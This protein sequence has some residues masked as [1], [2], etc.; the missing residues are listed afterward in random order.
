MAP[1]PVEHR[2]AEPEVS[3]G[4]CRRSLLLLGIASLGALAAG[5]ASEAAEARQPRSEAVRER[6][7]A[8][9]RARQ[10]EGASAPATPAAAPDG[11]VEHPYAK[12][13][14]F[15]VEL[16]EEIWVNTARENRAIPWRAYLPQG[17]SKAPMV[18][19]SHGGGGTRESGRIYG[20]H[21]ASH[22]I[23]ALHLQHAGS[24][25]DAFRSNPQQISAAARDPALARPRFEDVGYAAARLA[26][27][28][29]PLAGRIDAERLGI[30]GHSFG[31]ITTLIVAGQSVTGFG[32]GF[33]LPKLLGA[34]ALSPSPP[35]AGYGDEATAFGD[36]LMPIFHLTGTED[37]APNG[38]FKAP[39]RR[40][41]FD[42]I[43]DVEQHLL[44]LKGANHFTFGGDP[45][46]R[47]GPR[48]FG[49][50]E[51]PRHHQLILAAAA[52]FWLDRM[53]QDGAARAF[54]REGGLA[55]LLG[56]GDSLEHKKAQS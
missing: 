44:I 41:P 25:R 31:A 42:R 38:D 28:P 5:C 21:L 7:R 22:G 45:N 46:P 9:L 43:A 51:L 35:R 23:A 18:L 32:Q 47:L 48:N 53:Q 50:P 20:E 27:A 1:Y 34:F 55:G 2:L 40:I 52:A 36:M 54:L 11:G 56:A 33:G 10:A 4:R 39:A 8:R 3:D 14:R 17:Q 12:P 19:Y 37:D 49:Y 30:A 24:D 26:Q 29:G 16:V 13:G 6:L 15:G